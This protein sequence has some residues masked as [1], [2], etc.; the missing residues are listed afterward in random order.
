MVE[1]IKWVKELMIYKNLLDRLCMILGIKNN[2]IKNN[3]L[4]AW[5]NL[6]LYCE[7]VIGL[8]FLNAILTS[9]LKVK[10]LLIYFNSDVKL[11][12]R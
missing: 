11:F 9:F 3:E 7:F 5:L 2:R 8:S 1:L 12:V 10:L 6:L 4:I